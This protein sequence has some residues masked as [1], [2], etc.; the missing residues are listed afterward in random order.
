MVGLQRSI[1]P[2][3]PTN[4]VITPHLIP[5]IQ[6]TIATMAAP[7]MAA[8]TP[9]IR[10]IPSNMTTFPWNVA[11]VQ[12]GSHPLHPRPRTHLAGWPQIPQT[13]PQNYSVVH[14]QKKQHAP[15]PPQLT[16]HVSHALHLP[17][18]VTQHAHPHKQLY[19]PATNPSLQLN[20]EVIHVSIDDTKKA[21]ERAGLAYTWGRSD[22]AIIA[23][24]LA[25]S[26]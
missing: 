26:V 6:T 22:V 20:D 9:N 3:V 1:R 4:M 25:R 19:Q 13:S 2:V 23:H 10:A 18:R 14:A 7:D 12:M 16:H 24:S 17:T 15:P 11:L 5:L 8:C 21:N